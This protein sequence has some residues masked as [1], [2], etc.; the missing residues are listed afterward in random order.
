MSSAAKP[1]VFVS[2]RIPDVG[3]QMLASVC[4]VEVWPERLPPSAEVLRQKVRGLDG[5]VTLLTDRVDAALL[6]AA[7]PSLKVVSNF[8]VGFN[9]IDVAAATARGVRIGNTPG[10]LTD[11]TADIAVTLLLAAARRLGESRDDARAGRWV[12]WEPTAWLG[13]DLV[14]RTVG[15]VGMGRIGYA[16]ARRLH[17]GWDMKVLYT[18]PR[19]NVLAER[20]LGAQRVPLDELLAQSD[21]VSL[22]ASL[23]ETTQKMFGAQQFRQ[24]KRTAVF[25]NTARGGHVDQQALYEALKNGIIFAAGIDVTDPEPLPPSDPLFTLPNLV[26]APHIASAT[27]QTRDAMARICAENLIAGLQ[28]RKM[29]SCV[30]PE[31]EVGLNP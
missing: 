3:L 24:M 26:I 14:G 6:D 18:S 8:A 29:T 31:L 13:C 1:R 12:T 16:T 9:N 23:N 11:A 10:V 2:R 30:N 5:L 7:G 20:E 15:I 19:P 4:D 17:R 27:Q 21:F 25:V 22:H 28:G